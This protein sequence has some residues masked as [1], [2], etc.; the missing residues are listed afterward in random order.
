ML[1]MVL[2]LAVQLADP[3]PDRPKAASANNEAA[4]EML[5]SWNARFRTLWTKNEGIGARAERVTF[6]AWSEKDK[7]FDDPVERVDARRIDRRSGGTTFVLSGKQVT[8]G[9]PA[10]GS[11]IIDR[12]GTVWVVGAVEESGRD[13]SCSVRK[14]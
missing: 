2:L 3:T 10:R 12:D 7:R 13:Y 8:G 11:E 9:R 14:K 4:A 5:L 1:L 6:R